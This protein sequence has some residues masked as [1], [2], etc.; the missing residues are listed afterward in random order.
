MAY[1]PP[2]GE[3]DLEKVVRSIRNAHERLTVIDPRM[4]RKDGALTPHE[5]LVCKTSASTTVT[6][7]A[8]AVVLFDSDGIGKRFTLLSE[9]PSITASGAN[10]L[11]TGAEANSTWYHIWAIAKLDETLDTLLS[12]SATAPTLPSDYAY[13]GYIGAV[14]NDSSGNFIA[15]FQKNRKA[16][17]AGVSVLSSG[18]ATSATSVDVSVGVPPTATEAWVRMV[19]FLSSGGPNEAQITLQPS[20]S[21]FGGTGFSLPDQTT[22]AAR[23]DVLVPIETAQTIY[24]ALGG[25][26]A[27]ANLVII[28]F[29]M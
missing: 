11:D 29:V 21:S 15:F 22:A 6:V 17:R 16:L 28:G 5:N 8:D 23:S 14:Y 10:G 3:K 24:Y 1:V 4:V 2:P 18:S 26:N 25:T 27:R 7:T 19:L 12:A 20:S 13:K 9:T